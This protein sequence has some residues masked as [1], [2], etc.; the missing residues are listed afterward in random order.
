MVG[1]CKKFQEE[2][3]T[4]GFSDRSSSQAPA[5][6]EGGRVSEPDRAI[7]LHRIRDQRSKTEPRRQT[8]ASL[9]TSAS[10]PDRD[11]SQKTTSFHQGPDQRPTGVDRVAKLVKKLWLNHFNLKFTAHLTHREIHCLDIVHYM[12]SV[13]SPASMHRF[14]AR[15]GAGQHMLQTPERS[16]LEM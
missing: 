10:Q 6:D 1:F 9:A 12:Q 16:L 15:R 3:D 2:R 11:R 5:D 8:G 4:L 7:H 13:T 14:L